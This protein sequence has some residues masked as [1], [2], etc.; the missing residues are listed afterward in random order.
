MFKSLLSGTLSPV[1]ARVTSIAALCLLVATL[2]LGVLLKHSYEAQGKLQVQVNTL[3]TDNKAIMKQSRDVS[4]SCRDTDTMVTDGIVKKRD[5]TERGL[6]L[7][8]ELRKEKPNGKEVSRGDLLSA[9][10]DRVLRL[11]ECSA[12]ARSDCPSR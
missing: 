10:T 8:E 3:K 9:D 6:S 12:K 2:A 5:N 11:A 7:I 1:I 4:E